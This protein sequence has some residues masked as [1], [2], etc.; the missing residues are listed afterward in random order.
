MPEQLALQQVFGDGATVDWYK[1]LGFPVAIYMQCLSSQ[2][3]AR[4]TFPRYQDISLAGSH[5]LQKRHQFFYRRAIAD[6]L[7]EREAFPKS[8]F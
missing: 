1:R 2:L 5:S 6:Q 3:L 7:F 8:F 4:T